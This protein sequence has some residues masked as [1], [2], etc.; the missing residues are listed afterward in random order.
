MKA[1][2]AFAATCA[3]VL[4]GF[5]QDGAIF[6]ARGG[7]ITVAEGLDWGLSPG[8]WGNNGKMWGSY[9]GKVAPTEKPCS[10]PSAARTE[11]YFQRLRSS[12]RSCIIR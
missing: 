7:R 11:A 9:I 10:L 12:E 5:A 2:I 4:G 6:L 8:L 1:L 3:L